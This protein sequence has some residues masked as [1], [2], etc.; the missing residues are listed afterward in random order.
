MIMQAATVA[1]TFA[2]T[3]TTT[4]GPQR[5]RRKAL[6]LAC[7]SALAA[8]SPLPPTPPLADQALARQALAQ[9]SFEQAQGPAVSLGPVP[10]HWWQLYADPALDSL[11]QQALQANTG[12]REARAHLQR[13][14]AMVQAVEAEAGP[15]A[16]AEAAAKRA[17]EAGETFLLKEKLPVM[18]EA[19]LGFSVSYQIDLF[20]Q[21]ARAEEAAHA[22]QQATAAAL[23][24]VRV[25]VAA[26]TVRAYVQ[27]CTATHELHRAQ[28]A[29]A[30]QQRRLDLAQR[31]VEAGRSPRTTVQAAQAQTLALQA[32]V[33]AYAATQD[34]AHY[35]LAALL[36]LPP[37][38][39]SRERT[40][41]EAPPR[42]AQPLPVGDGAALLQRRP[43]VREAERQLAA[44][45]ARIGVATAALYPSIRLGA[46]AGLSGVL[47][48]LGNASTARWG[49][50]P[51]ISWQ[52]PD[53]AAR[54][55]VQA[56]QADAQ[57]ALARF[58]GVVLK[59]LRETETSLS[60]Y[61]HDL[62]EQ[63]RLAQ[64]RE[65]ADQVA[66]DNRRLYE[67]GRAPL[68]S[69][70]EAQGALSRL[71]QQVAQSQG[72]TALDEVALFLALGGGWQ[73]QATQPGS[74]H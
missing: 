14:H 29:L 20:G 44:A 66:Q 2:A 64:A 16:S 6:V 12:L 35:K 30:V 34:A 10:D 69:Q 56:S 40:R 65:Q 41:C 4:A 24:V 26:A 3:V 31:L 23:D 28:A 63:A 57:A 1:A 67:S 52:I 27:G 7:A 50:G 73:Q 49:L 53:N 43:D 39:L 46:S 72:Q 48:D 8:C 19:N 42:L 37:Q 11:V 62:D 32:R 15:H 58:D 61:G 13:A 68:L 74:A 22:S 36:G 38:A 59:A 25:S 17:Q 51:L 47:G 71:D 45:T 5:W 55:R 21:L 9:A 70:L 54:A 18:N 33:P 60:R